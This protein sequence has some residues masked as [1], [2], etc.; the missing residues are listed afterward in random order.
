MTAHTTPDAPV[1]PTTVGERLRQQILGAPASRRA[2]L[3]QAS[4]ATVVAGV[5]GA[6]SACA[7][8]DAAQQAGNA[9]AAAG[10]SDH[11]GGS[12]AAHPAAPAA[13]PSA[14]GTGAYGGLT[15]AQARARADAMDAMHEKGVKA[16]PAKPARW[17]TSR[18]P[19]ASRT[20][21]RCS[22]SPRAR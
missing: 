14:L 11:G 1:T 17:A 7:E 4:L 15:L 2:F 8:G 5:G 16:F 6:L 13:I 18:S 10:G 19:R 9:A 3:R 21:S 20:A 12:M 22:S